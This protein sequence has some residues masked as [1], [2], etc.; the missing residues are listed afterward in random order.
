MGTTHAD[1]Y[2]AA[3]FW[4]GEA[5]KDPG[6]QRR[7]ETTIKLIPTDAKSILDVGCGNGIFGRRL[8]EVRSDIRLMGVDRSKSALQHV[9]FDSKIASIDNLPFENKSFDAVSCLQVIEHIPN[10]S[11][12]KSLE[13]L[14]R[15]AR[16]F[17]VIGVPFEEDLTKETTICPQCK[18]IFN[19]DFHLRRYD[20]S[21]VTDLFSDLG[22]KLTDHEFP[23]QRVRTKYIDGL[24]A[25]LK[26]RRRKNEQFLSPIC[27]VCGYTE[28]DKTAVNHQTAPPMRSGRRP[29]YKKLLLKTLNTVLPKET[30]NG[31]WIVALFQRSSS[32]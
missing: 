3:S 29:L 1:Y 10:A 24:S 32:L 17:I 4:E 5:L 30:V 7:I 31:Y 12:K 22:F 27:P 18:A 25:A 9:D 19:I 26:G 16:E 23:T 15:V 8:Q 13:E 20:L 21:T 14:A 2:E 11:Y 28:G 6:N